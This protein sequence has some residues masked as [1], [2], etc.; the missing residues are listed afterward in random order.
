MNGMRK[1][2]SLILALSLA[3]PALV[4]AEGVSEIEITPDPPENGKQIFTVRLRPDVTRTYEKIVFECVYQQQFAWDSTNEATRVRVH[5]PEV[6]TYP[7]KDVK[8]VDDLDHF[9]SFRVPIGMDKLIAIYG[10]TAFKT[11]VPVRVARMRITAIADRAP[12]WSHEVEAKG[13]HQIG[14]GAAAAA[15]APSP[16][17]ASP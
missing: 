11:N 17:A 3:M 4:F 8:L 5:E 12:A 1:T 10:L 14:G 6:F 2:R 7:R 13:L 15:A 9:I 16:K